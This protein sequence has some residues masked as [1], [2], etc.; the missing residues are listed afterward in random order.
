MYIIFYFRYCNDSFA[1]LQVENDTENLVKYKLVGGTLKLKTEVCPHKFH[2]QKVVKPVRERGAYEKRRRAEY[3]ENLLKNDVPSSSS[4]QPFEVIE[5]D[6]IATDEDLNV[7]EDPLPEDCTVDIP[8]NPKKSFRHK[9]VQ[10]NLKVTQKHKQVQTIVRRNKTNNTENKHTDTIHSSPN[11]SPSKISVS[12]LSSQS[13]GSTTLNTIKPQY[14]KDTIMK[15]STNVGFYLGLPEDIYFLTKLLSASIASSIRDILISLKKIRLNDSYVRLAIDFELSKSSV[16]KIFNKTIPLI[17]N[18]MKQLIF[19]PPVE[20]IYEKL[21]ISFRKR[22]FK[23]V[24]ILD[25]FEI[26]IEKPSSAVQQALT[27]SE[28]KHCNTIKYLISITPDGLIN[29]ISNGYGGRASDTIIF[30]DCN[31][32]QN[33]TPGCSVMADRGFKNIS[34]LLQAEG[35]H[36]I[37]PPSVTAGK[38]SSKLEV[39]ETKRIAA[40][41]INVE[42]TIGRLRD[43]SMVA[44]HAC[45]DT[46]VIYLLDSIVVIACGIVN[47]QNKLI[48]M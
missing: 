33:L 27:W 1:L 6:S 3:F 11:S 5:C 18:R 47:V 30:E 32:L 24:S 13:S 46:K 43:F 38:A 35:C 12:S 42:R 20:E 4:C 36:I 19:F 48:K 8:D 37:R 10:V 44:P 34:H 2:C 17:A 25:C 21:P 40:L 15:I 22:Y 7:P 41:R 26:R 14:C 45:I 9:R 16:C 39:M 29:F 31:F 28:Y 23:T